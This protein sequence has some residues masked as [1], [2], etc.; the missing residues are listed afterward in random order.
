MRKIVF[1][2]IILCLAASFLGAVQFTLDG[3]ARTRAAIYY[4]DASDELGMHIDSKLWLGA[5]LHVNPD[6]LLRVNLQ[7][8]DIVWGLSDEDHPG[9][10]ISAG[11]PLTAYEL[12]VDYRI[13]ALKSN[14]RVGQQYWADHRSLMLD[15]S[16][17][18]ITVANDAIPG[19]QSTLGW[20]KQVEGS[21]Y[22]LADD[23]NSFLLSFQ[24]KN[25]GLQAFYTLN[26]AGSEDVSTDIVTALPYLALELNPVNLDL[27]GILQHSRSVNGSDLA[28]GAAARVSASFKP[29]ELGV[30]ALYYSNEEPGLNYSLS[31]YY[32][33]K[34]YIF[35]IGQHFDG[36][37]GFD[38]LNWYWGQSDAPDMYL[39]IVGY[40]N[41]ALGE[42]IKLFGTGGMVRKTGWEANGG[43]ELNLNNLQLAAYAAYGQHDGHPEAS[44]LIGS[45]L[46]VFFY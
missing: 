34:L 8:G 12:Y 31:Q 3:E 44:Y 4:A 41:I 37:V 20:I 33:N 27:T 21:R 36:W 2:L 16:F 40:T 32:M 10:G 14:I 9:G 5:N 11:I 7:L 29:L 22:L 15:D 23:V 17:S 39:G 24:H 30:D 46:K 38:P 6:L 25:W 42:K 13:K 18:G 28:Y 1:A 26:E 35:G 45:T 43:L 19:M